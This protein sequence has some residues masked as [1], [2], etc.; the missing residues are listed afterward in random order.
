MLL[1]KRNRNDNTSATGRQTKR[2]SP[3]PGGTDE[4]QPI[5]SNENDENASAFKTPENQ[6]I[7]SFQHGSLTPV[8]SLAKSLEAAAVTSPGSAKKSI[9]TKL[10]DKSVPAKQSDVSVDNLLQDAKALFRRTAV[11]TRL[12]GRSQ[13]KEIIIE[14]LENHVLKNTSGCLYISGSPGTGKSAMLREIMADMEP[15]YEDITTHTVK[16]CSINCMSIKEPKAI[17]SKLVSELKGPRT[18]VETDVI[19]QAEK[20]L[21]GKTKAMHVVV[22][23]EIDHLLTKE[24][25]VLYKIFEWASIPT[26]RLV[27]IGIAN[28]LDLTDRLL[29]R[30]RAKNCE[31][32]LVNFN[33]YKVEEISAII[34]DRLSS[35]SKD[36]DT[37]VIMQP[38]AIE[39]C[40]RKVA[41]ATGDLRKALDVCRQAIEMSEIEAKKKSMASKPAALGEHKSNQ[42][43][44]MST[45]TNTA[46]KV[47]I[48][49]VVK[50][51]NVVFGS[52]TVQKIRQCNLQQK[53]A[54]GVLVVMRSTPSKQKDQMS[55]GRFQ[56]QYATLCSA[57]DF[58]TP[59]S[60]TELND[61]V[62]MLETSGL[63]TLA[64]AKEERQR[65]IN[66]SVQDAEVLQVIREIAVLQS[67]IDD[68]LKKAEGKKLQKK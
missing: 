50:V 61:L 67:W 57:S 34:K 35:L 54:L 1:S 47:T 37:P 33:P 46:P 49:H 41:A 20:L 6:R 58:I 59:V 29:P 26:S 42:Q 39:L 15:K 32:Q 2:H 24:Q 65:K 64:K 63:L 45:P 48:A 55:L 52:P 12:V 25:D 7:K 8:R 3:S 17:Y 36:K 56:E 21:N 53:V 28:A 68:A 10:T 4:N 31:P 11:P 43:I 13:E 30:L 38:Q 40:A 60:R 27:L 19:K 44:G 51:M 16:V 5:S 23:D 9:S 62:S 22:L 18:P 66:L 14:F